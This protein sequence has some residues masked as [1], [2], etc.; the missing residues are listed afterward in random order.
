LMDSDTGRT[1]VVTT[2]EIDLGGGKTTTANIW[3]PFVE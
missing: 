1:W 3:K 2:V